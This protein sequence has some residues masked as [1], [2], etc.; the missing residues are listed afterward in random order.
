MS[1]K[2]RRD[3]R[4]R[5]YPAVR[6]HET[7]TAR[8]SSSCTPSK[9]N[10]WHPLPDGQGDPTEVHLCLT[11]KGL[12]AQMIMRFKGPGTLDALITSLAVHRFNVWP[13]QE[14]I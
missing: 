8:C 9:V 1:G 12:D 2:K 14:G 4:N 7:T 6:S 3:T 10:S 13:T 5:T 11:V